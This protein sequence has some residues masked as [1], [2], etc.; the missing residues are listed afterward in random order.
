MGGGMLYCL[1]DGYVKMWNNVDSFEKLYKVDGSTHIIHELKL[2]GYYCK[3]SL[4]I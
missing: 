1:S 3:Y 2:Y 4:R